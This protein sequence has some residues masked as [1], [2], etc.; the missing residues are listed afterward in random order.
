MN[1][2]TLNDLL[3]FVLVICEILMLFYTVNSN[4]KK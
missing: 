1:Y 3:T 4:K 2:L